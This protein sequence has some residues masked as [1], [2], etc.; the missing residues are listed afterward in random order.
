VDV[1][2]GGSIVRRLGPDHVGLAV[3]RHLVLLIAVWPARPLERL[4]RHR[5]PRPGRLLQRGDY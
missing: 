5:A 3:R 2:H 1:R 4:E